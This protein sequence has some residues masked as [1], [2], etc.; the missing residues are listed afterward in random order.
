MAISK[1]ELARL[2]AESAELSRLREASA[3]Q[4]GE[5]EKL[6]KER[7]AE[8]ASLRTELRAHAWRERAHAEI[9]KQAPHLT[10]ARAGIIAKAIGDMPVEWDGNAPKGKWKETVAGALEAAGWT[11]PAEDAPTRRVDVV[12]LTAPARKLPSGPKTP[13]EIRQEI[14]ARLQ[15]Q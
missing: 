14:L 7:S 8:V 11:K 15:S 2:R 10:P 9:A 3:V 6:A 5:W 13:N 4:K 12:D 1:E